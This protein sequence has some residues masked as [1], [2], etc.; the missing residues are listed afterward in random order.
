MFNK[1]LRLSAGSAFIILVSFILQF[2]N[3]SAIND[4]PL[5]APELKSV[6]VPKV[7][8]HAEITSVTVG[9]E[10]VLFD[11]E[12]ATKILTEPD[13]GPAGSTIRWATDTIE[14]RM[15]MPDTYDEAYIAM[16]RDVFVWLHTSTGITFIETDNAN[17]PLQISGHPHNGGTVRAVVSKTG[18]I[19][20]AEVHIG[21]CKPRSAY[22]ELAQAMG[23]FG[24][25]GDTRSIFSQNRERVKP[26]AF[27]T[28]ILETLYS[29]APGTDAAQ[30]YAAFSNF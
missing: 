30:V 23:P 5:V 8:T 24:D 17:A 9:E 19:S 11:A 22:E 14:Y 6:E 10:P 20:S 1:I 27:D 12:M 29:L 7:E 21:C 15:Q 18:V 3:V 28:R 4:I 16:I 26:S 2:S 25:H 13:R